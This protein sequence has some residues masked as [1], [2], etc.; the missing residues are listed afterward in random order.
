MKTMNTICAEM[1]PKLAEMLFN[2]EA[3]QAGVKEHVESHIGAC[4]G[5]R[6]EFDSLRRTIATLDAW[7]APEPNPY[8]MTRFDARLREEKNAPRASWPSRVFARVKAR[9]TYGP[10]MQARPLAAMALTLCVLVGGGSYLNYYWEQPPAQPH[11][12]DAAVVQDL[13]TLDSNSQL[14]DQLESIDQQDNGQA[15][16]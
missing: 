2:P 3:V 7:P 5:C 16:E 1:E 12:T 9:W 11:Q 10:Q 14:L 6:T 8:F 4:E 13:Q 15:Q